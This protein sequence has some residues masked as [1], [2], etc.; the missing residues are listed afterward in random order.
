M[1]LY[2][3]TGSC[4]L[5]T[6][7]VLEWVGKPFEVELIDKT[8]LKSPEFLAKNPT[9]QVPMLEDGELL[10]TQGAA[11]LN[12]VSDQNPQ[13]QLCGEGNAKQRAEV[14]RW[15]SFINSDLHPAFKPLFGGTAYLEDEAII[16]KTQDHARQR[17]RTLFE[18]LDR[19]LAGK[20]YLVE[21]R[22]IAD[23]YL[24]VALLWTQFVN[25][26]LAGL[27][28]IAAFRERMAADAAVQKALVTQ[29]LA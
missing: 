1:K 17:L 21:Q 5:A 25:V 11:I 18:I 9:G 6:N 27:A 4:A 24:F 3:F 23:A 10:L 14:Q 16:A 7:I 26:D 28:N 8:Q 22:S 15:L 20:D 2:S 13:A 12:Y 19:Q 29:K